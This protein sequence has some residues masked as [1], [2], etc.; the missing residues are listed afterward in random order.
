MNKKASNPK[1]EERKQDF[2]EKYQFVKMTQYY[3]YFIAIFQLIN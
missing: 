2:V 3:Y 1:M